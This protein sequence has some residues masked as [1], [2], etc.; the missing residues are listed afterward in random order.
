M[1][2]FVL[3]QYLG[4]DSLKYL[5]HITCYCEITLNFFIITRGLTPANR[6]FMPTHCFCFHNDKIFKE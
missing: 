3:M 1:S 4:Q 2:F 5:V 6:I